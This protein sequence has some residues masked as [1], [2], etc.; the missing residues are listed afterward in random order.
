MHSR[1]EGKGWFF[2]RLDQISDTKGDF[3]FYLHPLPPGIWVV[4]STSVASLSLGFQFLPSYSLFSSW[5][6]KVS[7]VFVVMFLLNGPHLWIINPW[8]ETLRLEW[9]FPSFWEPPVQWCEAQDI[10]KRMGGWLHPGLLHPGCEVAIRRPGLFPHDWLEVLF[11][12][13]I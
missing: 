12:L 8:Y 5:K 10:V 2:W 11:M 7:M 1:A 13:N 9:V 6:K 4:A 3:L